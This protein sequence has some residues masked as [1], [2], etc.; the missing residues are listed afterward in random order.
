MA[1]EEI[2]AAQRTLEAQMKSVPF[3]AGIEEGRWKVLHY[4]FP[5]LEFRI[6]ARDPA[7]NH[8]ESLEFQLK[9]D[10]YSALAPFVQH[11]DHVNQVRPMPFTAGT[12]APGVVDALKEWSRDGTSEYGG[13]YR[14]WQRHASL[15]N[16]WA[17]KRPDQAWRGDRHITFILE[18]LYE[19]VSEH[20]S[21]LAQA[22]AA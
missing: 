11:W 5:I 9:C 10:N 19:L 18:K 20:A 3:Q 13:I 2:S 6:S 15:H 17:N 14:A 21:W 4:A 16:D 8:E 12:S 22:N 1:E 7:T